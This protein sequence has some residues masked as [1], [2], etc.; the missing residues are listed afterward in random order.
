MSDLRSGGSILFQGGEV[1]FAKDCRCTAL[2][3]N[4]ISFKLSFDQVDWGFLPVLRV[5]RGERALKE[6]RDQ[7]GLIEP[8]D[9][10]TSW[11]VPLSSAMQLLLSPQDQEALGKV[12]ACLVR[13]IYCD[14]DI[15]LVVNEE[16]EDIQFSVIFTSYRSGQEEFHWIFRLLDDALRDRLFDCQD[17]TAE[18]AT[19]EG[20]GQEGSGSVE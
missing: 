9:V 14:H 16:D 1:Q 4:D 13:D 7:A 18:T 5:V 8:D 19:Q 20:S 2:L 6:I 12:R 17:I 10:P 11:Q 3:S 15:S